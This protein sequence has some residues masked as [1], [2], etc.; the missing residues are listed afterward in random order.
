M[1]R[2]RSGGENMKIDGDKIQFESRAEVGAVLKMTETYRKEHSEVKNDES[3][4]L[5][6][7]LLDYM[8]MVW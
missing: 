6:Y 8:E 2:L 3:I 1:Q 5:F 7:N 4:K